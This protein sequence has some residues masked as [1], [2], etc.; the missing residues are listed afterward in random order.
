MA[1]SAML[2]DSEGEGMLLVVR[3][4]ALIDVCGPFLGI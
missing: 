3:R 2:R 4:E 1:N